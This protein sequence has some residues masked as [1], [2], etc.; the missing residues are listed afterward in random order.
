ME[1]ENKAY[2]VPNMAIVEVGSEDVIR[3]SGGERVLS[4]LATFTEDSTQVI[5]EVG[6]F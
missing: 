1:K 6:K 2:A 3:T 5:T 4:P